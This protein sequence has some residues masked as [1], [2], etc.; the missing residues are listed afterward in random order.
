[1]AEVTREV[2]ERIKQSKQAFEKFTVVSGSMEPLI[3]V[4]AQII[5][6]IN[7]SPKKF[8]VVAFWGGD[9]L[10]CHVL[11]HEN[12][13]LNQ[14]AGKIYRTC[15]LQAQAVDLSITDDDLLGV[16]ENFRLSWWQKIKLA[17]RLRAKGL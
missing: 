8:D 7:A 1:M 15:P 16:V 6:A 9:R 11:W 10:I 13:F 14:S 17:W 2:F 3:K 4:G 12:V 5:V